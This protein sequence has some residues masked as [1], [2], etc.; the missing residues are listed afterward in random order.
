MEASHLPILC[1]MGPKMLVPMRYDMD[2]GRKA[3][4]CCQF[5]ASMVSIIQRG[6]D[7]SRMAMPAFA[8]VKAPAATRM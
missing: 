7:G 1:P 2:A 5:V 4:P 8:K 6:R 3:A